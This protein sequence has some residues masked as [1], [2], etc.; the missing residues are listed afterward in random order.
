MGSPGVIL[1]VF[2]FLSTGVADAQPPAL[3]APVDQ[4]M[5]IDF[6]DDPVLALARTNA[7]RAAFRAVIGAAVE[8][9]PAT[10]EGI[11]TREEAEA[12]RSEAR[13]LQRPSID[14]SITSFHV[15]DRAFSNDPDNIIER[16]RPEQRTDATLTVNQLLYDF[17][18]SD[19][20]I[21]AAS[22]RIRAA[23][24]DLENSADAV[25]LQAVAA[26][27]DVFGYRALVT[28]TRAFLA[29]QQELRS[30]VEERI[31]AGASAEG[32]LARV[33]SFIADGEIR[34]ARYQ[35]QVASA[36]ARLAALTGSPPP[37]DLQRAPAPTVTL[38]SVDAAT[39]AAAGRPAVRSA[40]ASAAASRQDA[41]AARRDRLPQVSGGID[42]G[43]Y[44]VFE[45]ER[46][47]DVRGRVAIRQRLFGGINPRAQQAGARARAA[48][49][50]ADRIREEA[51]REASIAWADVQALDAQLVALD[52]AYRA[53]RQSRDVILARF[54]ALR[55]SLFDVI[56]AEQTYYAAASSFIEGLIQYDA[57]RYVLLSRTGRLLGELG[58]APDR[59]GGRERL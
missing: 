33:D 25:A 51:E 43:R 17:G 36:E 27:Y 50:R 19:A 34:L 55:G 29:G 14:A 32:D 46:D 31:R 30:A 28:L 45:T 56:S 48:D 8:R 49:A 35:R 4:P 3:P 40:E 23:A 57:A 24:A 59:Y 42:A 12:Q 6:A 54:R 41:R 7:P 44:G 2:L 11:A 10:A 1:T 58:I 20:R 37:A 52:R 53:S 39:E 13:E 21:H 15:I 26:W 16:S 5:A 47:Y 9:S 38:A 18:A 22:E